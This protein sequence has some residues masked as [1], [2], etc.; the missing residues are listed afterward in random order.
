[1]FLVLEY[2]PAESS[3]DIPS[4]FGSRIF[5][6]LPAGSSTL[7]MEDATKRLSDKDPKYRDGGTTTGDSYW[8]PKRSTP[9]TDDTPE[10][11]DPVDTDSGTSSVPS[12]V[13]STPQNTP[14]GLSIG[15]KA[16]IGVACSVLCLA[17][18]GLAIFFFFR[19]RRQKAASS[20]AAPF[21]TTSSL[22]AQPA[23]YLQDKEAQAHVADS[24]QSEDVPSRGPPGSTAM[25]ADP[26]TSAAGPTAAT[27]T[28]A[29]GTPS[30]PS[31]SLA[32]SE[33]LSRPEVPTT[34]AHLVEEG[35]TEAE[36][37]RLEEEER[38]LDQAIEQAAQ[39]K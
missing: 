33:T 29:P 3:R 37:R 6:L 38:A 15:A 34:V 1:M 28:A 31:R 36:I 11:I 24:P 16:G 23:D 25:Y 7:M 17:L 22:H 13:S 30:I 2:V 4:S 20:Q 9:V 19:Y 21:D 35:M 8:N 5:T 26:T 14:G 39:R 10:S 27:L 32:P 18:I 12:N